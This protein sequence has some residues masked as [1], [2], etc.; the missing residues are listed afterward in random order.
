MRCCP[1]IGDRVKYDGRGANGPC[2]GTVTAIYPTYEYDEINDRPTNRARPEIEWHV[3]MKP[4]VLPEKWCYPGRD[5]FAPC[6]AMLTKHH[7]PRSPN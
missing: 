5:T 4:D 3:G 2:S 7:G 6:V 1:K